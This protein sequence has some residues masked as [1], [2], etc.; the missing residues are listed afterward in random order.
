[1]PALAAAS[2]AVIA[3]TAVIVLPDRSGPGPE[4]GPPTR[5]TGTVG[6]G[7]SRLLV[8][9]GDMVE[10]SGTIIAAPGRPVVYCPDLPSA[11]VGRDPGEEPA[12]TCS[13]IFAVTLTGVDLDRLADPGVRRGVR[14]GRATLRGVWQD[15]TIEVREQTPP[16]ARPPVRPPVHDTV[17]CPAPAGGWKI[18]RWGDAQVAAQKLI[19]YVESRPDRFVGTGMAYLSGLPSTWTEPPTIV[20]EVI[21]VSVLTG[22][23]AQARRD[24]ETLYSGNLCVYRGTRLFEPAEVQAANM[25]MTALVQDTSNGIWGFGS[26]STTR[27]G[28]VDLL[29]LDERLYGEIEKMGL[30]FFDL[31]PAVRPVR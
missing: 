3:T 18:G 13:A 11:D 21:T 23:L 25:S 7:Q 19:A 29:V 22:D 28:Q 31:R 5:T 10:V 1:M 20:T 8:R 27:P 14:F 12:P 6:P 4:A 2:V 16:L 15:R 30:K 17:P 24:L 9:D 26:G